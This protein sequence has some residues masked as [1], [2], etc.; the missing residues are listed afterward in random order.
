M[1]GSGNHFVNLMT[2][3]DAMGHQMLELNRVEMRSMNLILGVTNSPLGGLLFG[4]DFILYRERKQQRHVGFGHGVSLQ[5]KRG[6]VARVKA[7]IRMRYLTC[8]K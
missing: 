8:V 2:D 4:F 5:F 3:G 6:K 7:L 1:V